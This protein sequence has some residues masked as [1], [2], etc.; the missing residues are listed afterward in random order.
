MFRNKKI[1]AIT[2]GELKEMN[3]TSFDRYCNEQINFSITAEL[4]DVLRGIPGIELFPNDR[5]VVKASEL[6]KLFGSLSEQSS[7]LSDPES[8]SNLTI[9]QQVALEQCKLNIMNAVYEDILHKCQA[10]KELE[11]A[12]KM[13]EQQHRNQVEEESKN[14]WWKKLI[15]HAGFWAYFAY[16]VVCEFFGYVAM[17]AEITS[18]AATTL[19]P[20]TLLFA[21][22]MTLVGA[23][24]YIAF[25]G[26]LFGFKLADEKKQRIRLISEQIDANEKINSFINDEDCKRFIST[27]AYS[28]YAGLSIQFN[29]AIQ[30]RI[31]RFQPQVST[32][33]NRM[34]WAAFILGAISTVGGGYYAGVTFIGTLATFGVVL[35]PPVMFLIVGLIIA[36]LFVAF[37]FMQSKGLQEIF[38]PTLKPEQ[39]VRDKLD[40]AIVKDSALYIEKINLLRVEQA[41]ERHKPVAMASVAEPTDPEQT[42]VRIGRQ[43]S[44]STS[45]LPQRMFFNDKAKNSAL[46][47]SNEPGEAAKS[48]I[49]SFNPTA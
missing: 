37:V 39:E 36:S 33:R 4:Y 23:M 43:R 9:K 48:E 40:T 45:L 28:S 46:G 30:R 17:M 20:A 31:D 35:T 11:I 44:V 7:D 5:D 8:A 19:N 29:D 25:E 24:L 18:V 34:Y 13:E 26:T 21:I 1:T 2:E 15:S 32:S 41:N 10:Q 22:P 42:T 14:V 38:M 3:S 47:H 16:N 27:N 49:S 12:K 6:C